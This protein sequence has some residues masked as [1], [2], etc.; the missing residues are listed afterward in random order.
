[1]FLIFLSAFLSDKA[2]QPGNVIYGVTYD[3]A[4]A[5]Y[6][7]L[8]GR[9]SF[10]RMLDDFKFK[11]IRLTAHWDMVEAVAGK[12]D[13]T[14]LDWMMSE[15]QKRNAKII[16]VV[17]QKTPRWPECHIPGWAAKLPLD[18]YRNKLEGYI[19]ATVNHFKNSPALE[20]WQVENEPFLAFGAKCPKFTDKNLADELKLVKS[21]D[22]NHL[23][24]TT[25]AGELSLWTHTA[26]KADLFGFTVY[27]VVWDENIGYWTYDY[28][29]PTAGY[30]LRL[31]AND[32]NI[33]TAYAVELQA[34]P[35]IPFGT[36]SS[37][38][39]KEQFKSMDLSRL[40][41]NINFTDKIGVSRAYLWGAEWWLWLEK[42]G[43][44]S[45]VEYVR[46]LRKE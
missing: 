27:R 14:E 15:A 5:Q 18:K 4:Y 8:D 3:P 22:P 16:L 25:D 37:T 36:L 7:G 30:R 26:D 10:I 31:A 41:D 24:M 20:I 35:W 43:D 46:T 9:A 13:F 17:G 21:L 28:I 32:R 23:T 45:F 33:D 34:E 2:R 42:Q 39:L 38:P 29:L 19:D 44:N 1:L 6:L 11:Y 12:K 40:K